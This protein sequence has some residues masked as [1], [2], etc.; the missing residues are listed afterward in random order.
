M[1]PASA[2]VT[3]ALKTLYFPESDAILNYDFNSRG[4]YSDHDVD[5]AVSLLF[6]GYAPRTRVSTY[7]AMGAY[8]NDGPQGGYQVDF[9]GDN[10]GKECNNPYTTCMHYRAYGNYNAAPS[11]HMTEVR[12]GLGYWVYGT[13]HRDFYEGQSYW[14]TGDSETVERFLATYTAGSYYD[15]ANFG[16]K[17]C[18]YRGDDP[19]RTCTGARVDTANPK[20]F[21]LND[22][23]ASYFP[24]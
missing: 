11:D 15:Y 3:G 24:M 21:W 2:A 23:L 14:Y 12:S 17:D 5:W 16:N 20:H 1:A 22:G 18:A 19:S 10:G 7:G 9:D 6:Y 4:S 8:W 13:T